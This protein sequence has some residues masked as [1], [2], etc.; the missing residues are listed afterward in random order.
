MFL[1]V[2][3]GFAMA[4]DYK[5]FQKDIMESYSFYKKS[6]ALTSKKENKDKAI[7]VVVKFIS[8]WDVLAKKYA[9]D[10]PDQLKQ[11][12]DFDKKIRRP[13][14]VGNEALEML[15]AGEVKKA[16]SHL[17]EVR[18]SLWR[19]RVDAGIVSLNDKIND[20]HEAME[21]VLD[22]MKEQTSPES[23]QHLGQRYGGW[24]AIKWAEIKAA[25]Y[26]GAD[27]EAFGLKIANGHDA[28]AELM[29]NL[30]KGDAVGAKKAGSKVKKSYKGIFFLPECS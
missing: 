20:F 1:L 22:G 28:I 12:V 2:V 13:M 3:P 26:Y 25:D 15:Q 4:S 14:E 8:S 24:L 7:G 10:V 9:N 19:M 29:E 5:V 6:L 23:L 27:K 18:Y 21:V 16:H 17:E 11:T 30:K